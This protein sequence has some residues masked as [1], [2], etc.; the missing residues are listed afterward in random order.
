MYRNTC[1]NYRYST[2]ELGL[3]KVPQI[4]GEF[5]RAWPK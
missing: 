1:K 4:V 3:L 2:V 5:C